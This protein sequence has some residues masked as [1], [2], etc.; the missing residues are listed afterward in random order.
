[1]FLAEAADRVVDANPGHPR[2]SGIRTSYRHARIHRN[3]ADLELPIGVVDAA[4]HALRAVERLLRDEHQPCH[5]AA[6][7]HIAHDPDLERGQGTAVS[8]L[9]GRRGFRSAG[10]GQQTRCGQ[11]YAGPGNRP[12]PIAQRQAGL[13]ERGNACRRKP[14]CGVEQVCPRQGE[15]RHLHHRVAGNGDL[16]TVENHG[17]A[18][19]TGMA[20]IADRA[21]GIQ[22]RLLDETGDVEAGRNA[23]RRG[24]H[25]NRIGSGL[26]QRPARAA[27]SH[28][29]QRHCGEPEQPEKRATLGKTGSKHLALQVHAARRRSARPMR[30]IL[31]S[32]SFQVCRGFVR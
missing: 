6:S 32:W 10:H 14:G 21:S 13:P 26:R 4:D 3:A 11:R 18:R 30:C 15:G 28:Q 27:G 16:L 24:N 31:E 7:H 23:R 1:M 8:R 25:R 20:R 22:C 29:G 12:D 19:Q 5:V 9:Q 2:R 17:S